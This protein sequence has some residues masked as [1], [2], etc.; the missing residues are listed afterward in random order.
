MTNA[1]TRTRF[2][3]TFVEIEDARAF[4]L[5]MQAE[6]LWR[7]ELFEDDEPEPLHQVHVNSVVPGNVLEPDSDEGLR[8]HLAE[9]VLRH[10]GDVNW[11]E[12]GEAAA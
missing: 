7:S 5:E 6:L 3:V 1:Q 11:I 8:R 2:E 12:W 4:L 9:I 10:N